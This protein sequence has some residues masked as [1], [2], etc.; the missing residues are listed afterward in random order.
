M[1]HSHMTIQYLIQQAEQYQNERSLRNVRPAWVDE[2][3][4]HAADLFV[5]LTGVGRVGYECHLADDRWEVSMFLGKI[6]YIGG[7]KDGES[8]HSNFQFE[9]QGLLK[10]F[11]QID[12]FVWSALP[13]VSTGLDVPMS[14]LIIEGTLEGEPISLRVFSVPPQEAGAG[15]KFYQDGRCEMVE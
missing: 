13:D 2:L 1:T 7:A 14:F 15:L 11:D 6:E 3:V 5:P 10:Y 4:D 8:R 9:V 12:R